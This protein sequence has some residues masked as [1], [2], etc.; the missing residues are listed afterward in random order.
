M[1]MN[2]VLTNRLRN[3][4]HFRCNTNT[5]E[6]VPVGPDYNHRSTDGS[7]IKFKF[8][9]MVKN[10]EIDNPTKHTRVF[11]T[12][13]GILTIQSTVCYNKKNRMAKQELIKEVKLYLSGAKNQFTMAKLNRMSVVSSNSKTVMQLV[14]SGIYLDNPGNVKIPTWDGLKIL[15][16][17]TISDRLLEDDHLHFE[18]Q[19]RYQQLTIIGYDYK[20]TT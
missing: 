12:N 5:N 9:K 7:L 18:E 4:S 16:S 8:V 20:F 15:P 14:F 2:Q 17:N 13:P 3:L 10:I 11:S 1:T 19:F 6:Y